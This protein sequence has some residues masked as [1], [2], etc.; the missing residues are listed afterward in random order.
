MICPKCKNKMEAKVDINGGCSGHHYSD[1]RCYCP[2][3]DVFIYFVCPN[4]KCKQPIL[5]SCELSD[6]YAIGRWFTEKYIPS[7]E[8]KIMEQ[9]GRWC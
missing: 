8:T 9:K 7:N 6:Q 5:K 2:S 3:P 4:Y 1:E